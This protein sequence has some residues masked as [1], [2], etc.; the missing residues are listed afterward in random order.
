MEFNNKTILIAGLIIASLLAMYLNY[1]QI[2]LAIVSGLVGYL[3]KDITSPIDL[4]NPE[5]PSNTN[6]VSAGDETGGA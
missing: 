2:A 5:A 1:E 6:E 3:S 4:N